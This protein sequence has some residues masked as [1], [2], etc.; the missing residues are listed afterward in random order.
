[1]LFSFRRRQRIS[2]LDADPRY[3]VSAAITKSNTYLMTP[4]VRAT[5]KIIDRFVWCLGG[6]NDLRNL[7]KKATWLSI[8]RVLTRDG[9]S[10]SFQID[11]KLLRIYIERRINGESYFCGRELAVS[12]FSSI[13]FFAIL[14]DRPEDALGFRINRYYFS[15]VVYCFCSLL[16]SRRYRFVLMI[17]SSIGSWILS[18]LWPN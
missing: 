7:L 14:G 2:V 3:R 6:M 1:M 12:F 10:S 13:F 11:L 16:H 9:Q 15:L 18:I 8:A 5:A 17:N 4:I